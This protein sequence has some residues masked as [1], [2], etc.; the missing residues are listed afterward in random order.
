VIWLEDYLCQWK[1]TLIVVSHAR[2][3]L[4]NVCTDVLHLAN[5]DIERFK[6]N[7]D[8]FEGQLVE[9][10]LKQN[11]DHAAS[12]KKKK[13]MQRFIDKNRAGAATSKM[14]QSRQKALDRM[15]TTHGVDV[16]VR[17]EGTLVCFGALLTPRCHI[18]CYVRFS[19]QRPL[20]APT[21]SRRSPSSSWRAA[22]LCREP[23]E[24]ASVPCCFCAPF[25]GVMIRSSTD[26][27]R[28]QVYPAAR[29]E[30]RLRGGQGALL[31]SN[32][33]LGREEPHRPCRP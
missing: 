5:K 9:R 20:T 3:F 31:Q 2:D 28:L 23:S 13:E 21:F 4:N 22:P 15:A 25:V 12:V 6:G 24:S 33:T 32:A 27:C 29:R 7:Y 26:T 16:Q 17:Y 19:I 30:L 11:R 18:P 1:K 10:D 8:S 14:A